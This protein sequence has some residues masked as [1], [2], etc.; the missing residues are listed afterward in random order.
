MMSA[1]SVISWS[2]IILFV[3]TLAILLLLSLP[4]GAVLSIAGHAGL[5]IGG[6]TVALAL[7]P[8]DKIQ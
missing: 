5:L 1:T 7:A 4:S 6:S 8:R 2:A 3:T